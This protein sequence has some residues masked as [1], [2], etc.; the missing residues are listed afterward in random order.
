MNFLYNDDCMEKNKTELNIDKEREKMS[1]FTIQ[2]IHAI[3]I[4]DSRS[5]PTLRVTVTTENGISGSAGVPSGAS[6]G[7]HEAHEL[8]D[9]DERYNKKG[10]MKA[11]NNVNTE[12]AEFLCGNFDVTNQIGVDSAMLHLDGTENKKRLGANAILGVSLACAHA[13]AKALHIPLYRY[14]GGV[15]A[16]FMPTPMMNI[17]NGGSHADN[18]VDFQ[19]FMIMPVGAK[20]FAEAV[21][22]GSEVFNA[23][24]KALHAGGHNT[25]VGDE[26]GFAP[27][28]RSNREA[29]EYIMQAISDAGYTPGTDVMLA[30]DVASGEFYNKSTGL[31]ELKGENKTFSRDEM[32]G[33]YKELCDH[34]PI[35]SIEDGID[36]N[37][38]EGT[39]ILTKAIGNKVQLV[40]DDLFVTNVKR[41]KRG[42]AAGAANAILIKPNQIGTLT[43][44][45]N[46][47]ET[48][49]RAGYTAVVSHRSG[50]TED[51]TIA[52]I[53]V[54]MN[55]GQIKTGSLSRSER[56]AKYNRLIE[57]ERELF[58]NAVYSGSEAFYNLK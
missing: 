7:E 5:N 38:F 54:G 49:K 52:D 24:K 18:S 23:L 37:D 35:I 25:A 53:A 29:V 32:I 58:G 14:I 12:I 28:L 48:A 16:H 39:A 1:A 3:E 21:R 6:T 33:F 50:E 31:Y 9:N 40:G 2:D 44:T 42:I 36:Q 34:Y 30:L 27:N 13:A 22:I 41:L 26:G 45:L 20:S 19:E 55:A 56:T 11:V 4:L 8:R 46:A 10:V 57:I 51:T 15:N 47:I 17:L 43:E